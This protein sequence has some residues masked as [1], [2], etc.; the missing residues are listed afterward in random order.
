MAAGKLLLLMRSCFPEALA[1]KQWH[2]STQS[3]VAGGKAGPVPEEAG[4]IEQACGI[5]QSAASFVPLLSRVAIE[6]HRLHKLQSAGGQC[7]LSM[8]ATTTP[9]TC[10]GLISE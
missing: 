10:T 4:T 8:P 5:C 2:L 6:S 3:D 9:Y 1:V 7:R